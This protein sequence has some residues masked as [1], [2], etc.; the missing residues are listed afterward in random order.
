MTMTPQVPA[1]AMPKHVVA[2]AARACALS[3]SGVRL[4]RGFSFSGFP[5]GRIAVGRSGLLV[6]AFRALARRGR[7][8]ARR[9]GRGGGVGRPLGGTRRGRDV[10]SACH[11][12]PFLIRNR[13]EQPHAGRPVP[14][15]RPPIRP[16][17]PTPAMTFILRPF[18]KV[19]GIKRV[20]AGDVLCRLR[21]FVAATPQDDAKA[22]WHGL[23][24]CMTSTP[25]CVFA[26][27][28]SASGPDKGRRPGTPTKEPESRPSEPTEPSQAR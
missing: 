20:I 5:L 11:E 27:D 2:G 24:C 15:R 14:N 4:F 10:E 26:E 18:G 9:I 25:C 12:A 3:L 13:H 19:G 1:A 23:H 8:A 6:G 17:Q 16:V 7:H 28:V 22:V 21:A